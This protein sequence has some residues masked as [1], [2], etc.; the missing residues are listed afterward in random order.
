MSARRRAPAILTALLAVMAHLVLLAAPLTCACGPA[1][2]DGIRT[3][4]ATEAP[5]CCCKPGDAPMPCSSQGGASGQ[6][7][8]APGEG[9]GC[10]ASAAP[11]AVEPPAAT[12]HAGLGEVA[13]AILPVL[14]PLATPPVAHEIVSF[15]QD[16]GPPPVP[17]G[18]VLARCSTLLI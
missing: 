3:A 13:V 7:A 6:G 2:G 8:A 10:A 15:D 5:S 4:S 9:G 12:A 14:E 16:V 17:I 1:E 11:C 18:L